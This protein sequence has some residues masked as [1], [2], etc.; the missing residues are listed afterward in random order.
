MSLAVNSMKNLIHRYVQASGKKHI[1]E[2]VAPKI[3][4]VNPTVAYKEKYLFVNLDRFSSVEMKQARNMNK[5]VVSQVRKPLLL[6][7]LKASKEDLARLTSNSVEDSYSRVMWTNPKDGKVYNL[8]KQCDTPE[9]NVV[10]RILDQE[11]GFVKEAVLQPKTILIPDVYKN[12][13]DFDL[14]HGELVEICAKRNNPFAR[15][16]RFEFDTKGKGE[17]LVNK[18]KEI[19][20]SGE[21]IDYISMSLANSV[22]VKSNKN[23]LF[24]HV[25]RA[26]RGSA[27]NISNLIDSLCDLVRKKTRIFFASSNDGKSFFNNFIVQ[28][29]GSEGVGSL[30]ANKG[31]VSA[32]SS[33]RNSYFT[34]HYEV[35]ELTRKCVYKDGKLYGFNITGRPGCDITVEQYKTMIEKR[36]KN[37]KLEIKKKKQ[38]IVDLDAKIAELKAKRT[39]IEETIVQEQQALQAQNIIEKSKNIRY[40]YANKLSKL[41]A[42]LYALNSKRAKIELDI[43]TFGKIL[44]VNVDDYIEQLANSSSDII[45]GTSWATPVRTAKVALNDMMEGIL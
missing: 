42:E 30:S 5:I 40:K 44:K 21:K 16:I 27:P 20:M 12:I 7:Y 25:N 37:L 1:I 10:V 22:E 32:F 11:G 33:S 43:H 4:G 9:G 15:Y 2:T 8:L 24:Y 6:Q 28:V 31:K 17:G 18:L 41:G 34:Q 23:L 36:K 3:S 19:Q 29:K 26:L 38:E 45:R 39:I 14:A 13:D 35:G